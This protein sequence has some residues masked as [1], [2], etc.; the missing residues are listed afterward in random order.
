MARLVIPLE[1]TMEMD[2]LSTPMETSTAATMLMVKGLEK[3]NIS[4]PTE[5]DT[6]EL[7]L[8]IRNMELVDSQLK[9]KDNTMVLSF[10]LR[11]MGKWSEAWRRNLC[12]CQ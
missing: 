3:E 11:T 7:L 5:I 10:L 9:T 6:M 12:I 2:T 1:T 4:M 8:A